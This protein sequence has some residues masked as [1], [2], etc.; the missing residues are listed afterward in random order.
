MLE[1][2]WTD[3]GAIMYP[4]LVVLFSG[5]GILGAWLGLYLLA[6][7]G[8]FITFLEEGDSAIIMKG[9]SVSRIIM[10]AKGWVIDKDGFAVPGANPGKALYW[11]GIPPWWRI[12]SYLFEWE[13]GSKHPDDPFAVDTKTMRLRRLHRVHT[14]RVVVESAELAD[15]F[16]IDVSFEVMV[17]LHDPLRAVLTLKGRWFNALTTAIRGAVS[18]FVNNYHYRTKNLTKSGETESWLVIDKERPDSDFVKAIM[19]LNDPTG[20]GTTGLS[21]QEATG[22]TIEAIIYRDFRLSPEQTEAIKAVQQLELEELNGQAALRKAEYEGKAAQ[23]KARGEARAARLRRIAV[24][25]QIR[26][27]ELRYESIRDSKITTLVESGSGTTSVL[28]VK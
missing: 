27:D 23:T 8:I 16:S 14:Y 3:I 11:V 18:D 22:Y 13:S 7:K 2:N 19:K 10:N 9:K 4:I 28:P 6:L 25:D 5:L 20:S 26:K 1:I 15:G 12:H 21:I 17:R 24:G